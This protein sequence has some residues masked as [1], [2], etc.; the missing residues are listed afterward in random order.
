MQK[1]ISWNV[2][3]LRARMPLIQQLLEKESPDVLMLQETKIE[4]DKFPSLDFFELGY[5]VVTSGQKA[6]NGVALL[7]K[8]PLTS[9]KRALT[10]FEDQARFAEGTLS[11]GLCFMTAYVPNGQAPE[12]TPHDLTRLH[13]KLAWM[14]E[15]V[16]MMKT[17]IAQKIPF[18]LGGDF[19]VIYEDRDVYNAA[20]FEG[21]ALIVP[22]VREKM[23]KMFET[24]ALNVLRFFHPED[25]F[26]TFWDFQGGAWPRNRGILLD[27]FFVSPDLKD[28]LVSADVLKEYRSLEKPSDHAPIVCVIKS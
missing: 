13:Y 20:L 10:G 21:N 7:S 26:Y 3:S 11:S 15:L 25:G 1:I 12:K 14:D 4:D 17:K 28:K 22:P 6:W 5:R 8:E 2:A 23:K 18:I 19:N 16:R 24:G 27:G 9:L